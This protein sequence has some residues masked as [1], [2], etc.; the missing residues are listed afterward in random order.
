MFWDEQD[1]ENERVKVPKWEGRSHPT[2]W[3]LNP[4]EEILMPEDITDDMLEKVST[5]KTG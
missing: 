4:N 5:M 3:A 2:R 1:I